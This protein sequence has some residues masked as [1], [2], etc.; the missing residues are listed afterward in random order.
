MTTTSNHQKIGAGKIVT[1]ACLLAL[2][3][4]ALIAGSFM[5]YYRLNK[6]KILATAKAKATMAFDRDR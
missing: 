5:Y 4:T 2:V 1:N 3:W 6:E